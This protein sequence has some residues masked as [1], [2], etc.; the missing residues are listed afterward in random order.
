MVKGEMDVE[1]GDGIAA[2]TE[3]WGEGWKGGAVVWL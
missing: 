1:G 2:F 3:G